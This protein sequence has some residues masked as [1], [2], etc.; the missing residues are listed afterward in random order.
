MEGAAAAHICALYGTP[1]LEV[2]GISNLVGDRDRAAWEVRRAVAA[3]SW[4]ARAI[5][6]GLGQPARGGTG[7][8]GP[9]ERPDMDPLRL[10]YSPCPNDT[11]IFHAWVQGLLPDAPPVE[12]RLEDIDT[13]NR[14]AAAGEADVI[15][16]SFYA[17]G[18]LRER[19]ALAAFGRSAGARLRSAD[20]GAQGFA[21]CARPTPR[22]AWRRSPTISAGCG[23]PSRES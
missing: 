13:L 3:A 22:A 18:H 5:V 21:S 9:V 4:A 6:D 14:L 2:R 23:W 7:S 10:A 11:F 19:Y 8:C 15:K 1:F 16:V 12:E 17:F 20:R